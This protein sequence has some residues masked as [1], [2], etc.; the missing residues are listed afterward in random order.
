MEVGLFY[1]G[2]LRLACLCRLFRGAFCSYRLESL[3]AA[4]GIH[5]FIG[6]SIEGVALAADFN[7]ELRLRG[8]HGKN[9]P[10]RAGRFGFGK[11]LWV[12]VALHDFLPLPPP[13]F[14][15]EDKGGV[16]CIMYSRKGGN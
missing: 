8:T 4:G 12:D 7:I 1:M 13:L 15:G 11:V 5:D 9:R 16:M 10:A 14:R 3:H 6:A 2:S